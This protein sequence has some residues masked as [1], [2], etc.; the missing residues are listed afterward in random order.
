MELWIKIDTG[1][2]HTER[3]LQSQED[4]EQLV[5]NKNSQFP[6]FQKEMD[7]LDNNRQEF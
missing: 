6:Y 5:I 2:W 7:N 3:L 4:L 1:T